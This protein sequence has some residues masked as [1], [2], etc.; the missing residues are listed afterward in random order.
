MVAL[1]A[2]Q[3]TLAAAP[4][5]LDAA[6]AAC[7]AE[8]L[9]AT[10][11]GRFGRLPYLLIG[12]RCHADAVNPGA[13]EQVSG[14]GGCG[15]ARE[16]APDL[17]TDERLYQDNNHKL[18][19][20]VALSRFYLLHGFRAPAGAAERLE[21]HLEFADLVVLVREQGVGPLYRRLMVM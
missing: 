4:R 18:E 10:V 3:G 11:A 12:S 19:M 21:R 5:P 16:S 17:A 7:P 14:R 9:G 20:V 15:F 13:R 2:C 6:I 1:R 8:L